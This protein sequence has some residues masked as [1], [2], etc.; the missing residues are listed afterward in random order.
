MAI[1]PR[2]R[3]GRSFSS[4]A[5][6]IAEIDSRKARAKSL[7]EEADKLDEECKALIRGG[8]A[9]CVEPLR[10]QERKLRKQANGTEEG[11]TVLKQALAE[12]RT[13]LLPGCGYDRSVRI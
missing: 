9:A 5:E 13:E 12:F 10:D 3:K 6:I 8:R 7:H 4:E 1:T 11:L 2:Q